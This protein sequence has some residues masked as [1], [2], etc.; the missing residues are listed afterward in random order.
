MLEPDRFQLDY[1]LYAHKDYDQTIIYSSPNSETS[2]S[3]I[4][5]IWKIAEY[6]T[7]MIP[8]PNARL[9]ERCVAFV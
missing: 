7:D 1:K 8:H 9:S 4:C 3:K 2:K 5:D 6:P